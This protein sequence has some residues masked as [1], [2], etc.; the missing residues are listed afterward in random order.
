MAA[1]LRSLHV[2]SRVSQCRSKDML[3]L[4]A[5]PAT[6]ISL[7]DRPLD[8]LPQPA[9]FR[10]APWQWQDMQTPHYTGKYDQACQTATGAH[11]RSF[12]CKSEIYQYKY[13]HAHSVHIF[14]TSLQ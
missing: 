2:M 13:L 9:E 5:D 14:E 10:T 6:P 11:R 3:K 8:I 4:S 12:H 1:V 7:A